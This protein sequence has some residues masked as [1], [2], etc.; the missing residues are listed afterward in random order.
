MGRDSND[1]LAQIAVIDTVKSMLQDG[2]PAPPSYYERKVTDAAM[3]MNQAILDLNGTILDD[4][5]G[6]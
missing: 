6:I 5:E 2:I 3:L 1:L 4:W